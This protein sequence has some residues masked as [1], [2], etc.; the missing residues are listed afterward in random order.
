MVAEFMTGRNKG[1]S[2]GL[3]AFEIIGAHKEGRMGTEIC[4]QFSDR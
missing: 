4:E 1:G 3:D 2:V